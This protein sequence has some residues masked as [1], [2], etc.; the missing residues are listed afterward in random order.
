[1]NATETG[2]LHEL[3]EFLKTRRA[4]L[5]PAE[6]GLPEGGRRRTPG[7]RRAEVAMLAGMSVDWYTWLE[8]GRDIQASAQVLDSLARALRLDAG[9]RRHLYLL[10]LKQ[11]PAE[12]RAGA[13]TVSPTLQR[14][15]D[16]QG[17]NPAVVIDQR[18]D[19]VGWNEAARLTYGD[20]PNMTMRDR[21]TLWRTFMGEDLRR[22][23]GDKWEKQARR[24]MAQF[25]ANFAKF[26]GDSWWIEMIE[27]MN[28]ASPE[29]RA[30]WPEHDILDAE[31][32]TK[33]LLHPHAGMLAFDHIS[34]HPTNAPEL[35]VTVNLPL[36]E[37]DTA[38]KLRAL[39]AAER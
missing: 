11:L 14:L 17:P 22:M 13:G 34:F 26:P 4:R 21:N 15:L 30:W 28:E 33:L 18:M 19:L 5:T 29:F 16:A 24:R 32:G 31:E 35:T 36:P 39:M 9:E 27:A 2:R 20:Y 38:V 25:R 37:Y 7:L 6:A 12:L 8:Q 23:L 3:A 10:A 1:M